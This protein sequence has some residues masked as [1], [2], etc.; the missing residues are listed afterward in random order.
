MDESMLIGIGIA[1]GVLILLIVVSY[2]KT[3][4]NQALVISG[5]PRRNPKYL[6]G[7]G[8]LRIPGLQTVDRLYL[9]QLSVDIKTDS[10]VPTSDFR[11]Y[12]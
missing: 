1:L 8:G 7:T 2:V 11:R 10:S 12:L 4:P 5:W 6:I 3:S 9:G